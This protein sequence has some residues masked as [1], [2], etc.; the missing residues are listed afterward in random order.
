M[1]IVHARVVLKPGNKP[2]FLEVARAC[3][4]E[5]RKETGCLSYSAFEDITDP[6]VVIFYEEWRDEAAVANHMSL[7]HTQKLLSTAPAFIASPPSIRMHSLLGTTVL[8]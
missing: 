4:A 6:D 2:A 3:I 8:A 7:P 1:V 5:T